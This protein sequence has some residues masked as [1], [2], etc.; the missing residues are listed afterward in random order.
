MD[1]NK[2]KTAPE[3]KVQEQYVVNVSID[4]SK[5]Q[6]INCLI[7]QLNKEIQSFKEAIN[8]TYRNS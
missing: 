5:L 8:V 2:K 3:P 6:N 1:R 7:E 4:G